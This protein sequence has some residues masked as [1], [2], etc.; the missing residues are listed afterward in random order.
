MAD[1]GDILD[2]LRQIPT[3]PGYVLTAFQG[4]R[5]VYRR[6]REWKKNSRPPAKDLIEHRIKIRDEIERKLRA[7]R[8]SKEPP[9]PLDHFTYED[10]IIHDVERMDRFPYLDSRGPDSVGVSPWLRLE[11]NGLYHRGIEVF[12]SEGRHAVAVADED[13]SLGGWRFLEKGEDES[14]SV[15]AMP[16]GRIPF[17]FIERIDWSHDEYYFAPHFYCR[18]AGR[19]RE[20]YEE[21][22]YK[23]ILYPKSRH[24][25]KLEGLKR[26]CDRWGVVRRHFF[27]LRRDCLRFWRR[28][29]PR[30]ERG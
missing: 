29:R 21:V 19:M 17:D 12:L 5:W 11:V 26:D 3:I 13:G 7:E 6:Y 27:F 15:Y 23:A 4:G 25:H 8:D 22:V 18:Y 14:A 2:V 16:I 20:P 10:I 28:I 24:Y 30:K 1:G 9:H